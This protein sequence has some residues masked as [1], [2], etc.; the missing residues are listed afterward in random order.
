MKLF[1]RDREWTK[2]DQRQARVKRLAAY[3]SR[4]AQGILHSPEYHEWMRHEQEWFNAGQPDD[5]ETGWGEYH[6]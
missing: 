2:E 3:K 5:G 1:H 4:V 6:P